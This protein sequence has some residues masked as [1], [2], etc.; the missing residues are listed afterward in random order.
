MKY[1]SKLM[2]SKQFRVQWKIMVARLC[3]E[4][5]KNNAHKGQGDIQ[6]NMK[7]GRLNEIKC[8]CFS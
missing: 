6:G 1:K 5:N 2:T 4:T 7:K 8:V 3:I